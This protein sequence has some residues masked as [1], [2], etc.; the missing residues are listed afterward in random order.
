MIQYQ[1]SIRRVAKVSEYEKWPNEWSN[2]RVAKMSE[3]EDPGLNC[4]HGDTKITTI[5]RTTVY[6]N[7]VETSREYFPKLK[8]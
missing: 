8:T 3:N 2:I 4:F 6:K 1:K 5:C 7:N